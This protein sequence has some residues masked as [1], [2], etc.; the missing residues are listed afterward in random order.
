M[1]SFYNS[2]LYTST[3]SHAV[4]EVEKFHEYYIVHYF[5]IHKNAQMILQKEQAY[6]YH[7]TYSIPMIPLRAKVKVA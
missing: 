3:N 1:Y 2:K 6:K 7:S 5:Y 4:V